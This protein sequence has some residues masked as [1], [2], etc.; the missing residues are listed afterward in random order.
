M[1][2]GEVEQPAGRIDAARVDVGDVGDRLEGEERDADRQL[3]RRRLADLE[4]ADR[5]RRR[6]RLQMKAVYL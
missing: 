3:D 6:D 4:P 2:G 5:Q 1:V